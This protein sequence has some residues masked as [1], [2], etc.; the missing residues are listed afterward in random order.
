MMLEIQQK[1]RSIGQDYHMAATPSNKKVFSI[2][3]SSSS[4]SRPAPRPPAL[5]LLHVQTEVYH[6]AHTIAPYEEAETWP[7]LR[8]GTELFSSC[9]GQRQRDKQSRPRG[10]LCVSIR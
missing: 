7:S 4:C 2:Q 5:A 9:T 6:S 10:R 1:R 3:N 8:K